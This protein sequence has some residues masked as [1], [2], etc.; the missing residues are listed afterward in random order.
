MPQHPTCRAMR[1]RNVH[2]AQVILHAVS[3]NRLPMVRRRLDDDDRLALQPG[4]IYVWEERNSNPLESNSLESIQRFT[5]GRAWG[6]SKARDDFLLY[7]EKEGTSRAS[8]IQRNHGLESM[9]LVKQTY[10]AYVDG[11]KHSRKWHLNAYYSQ[12][13]FDRLLT[14]DDIPELR[15]V[16]VPAG[17]YT[18]ARANNLKR[19]RANNRHSS[20]DDTDGNDP[21]TPPLRANTATY[22]T[23]PNHHRSPSSPY[24]GEVHLTPPPA[25]ATT[26][27]S[28]HRQLAPLQYL[29]NITPRIRNPVDDAQL[30][31]LRHSISAL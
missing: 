19:A 12:A 15:T 26:S 30:R 27:S 14:I 3:Q 1:V 13:T 28:S 16:A 18:C 25:A 10:S 17:Q 8:I 20:T 23:T 2:D 29:E 22:G 6:P 21:T 5:D 24:S 31:A 7:Y 4:H 9:H 11:P